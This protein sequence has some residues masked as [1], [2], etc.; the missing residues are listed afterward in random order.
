MF[1][2]KS[3]N[4]VQMSP[5]ETQLV[6]LAG[7]FAATLWVIPAHG[8]PWQPG[9]ECDIG[10]IFWRYVLFWYYTVASRN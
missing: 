1:G 10:L 8:V 7:A 6:R 2:K 4:H 3:K 9:F 5:A